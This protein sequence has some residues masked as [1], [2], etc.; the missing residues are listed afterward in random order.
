[1]VGGDLG[2]GGDCRDFDLGIDED[3][4]DAKKWEIGRQSVAEASPGFVPGIGKVLGHSRV[5]DADGGTVEI[6]AQHQWTIG[7]LDEVENGFGL[8]NL[9]GRE[10]LQTF[11][12]LVGVEFPEDAV[13]KR[14]AVRGDD[15]Y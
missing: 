12:N 10:G 6:S 14:G 7:R 3:P 8:A 4:I 5:P 1:M 2:L 11:G 13:I 9:G 15:T